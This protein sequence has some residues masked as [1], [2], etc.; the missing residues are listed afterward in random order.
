MGAASLVL[1]GLLAYANVSCAPVR[2]P[3]SPAGPHLRV[4]TWNVNWGCASPAV[5]V[6]SLLRSGADVVCLQETTPAWEGFLRPGAAKTYPH[7]SFR[8]CGAAGGLACLAKAP[9]RELSLLPPTAGWFPAWAIEAQTPV[10][11]V[12]FL[13]VHL[14]PP[15]SERGGVGFLG[16]AYF[17]TQ[18]VRREEMEGFGGAID[19][20]RPA[21]VLG[22]F[23]EGDRGNA[24][25]WCIAHGMTDALA[26]YDR[27]T[28]TWHWRTSLGTMERRLDHILYSSHLDCI[29]AS[30]LNC[31]GSDHLPVQAIFERRAE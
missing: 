6:E 20:S 13:L 11:A 18:D 3:R 27:K 19:P 30:V 29:A 4:L 8:H 22:D 25:R 12:Q 5:V 21:I 26:E 9:F 24:V 31:E 1:A 28:D 16:S 15:L 10:G 7:M 23:N 17:R 14:R 2:T